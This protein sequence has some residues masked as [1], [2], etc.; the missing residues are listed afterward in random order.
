MPEYNVLAHEN[1]NVPRVRQRAKYYVT[2]AHMQLLCIPSICPV[3]PSK[4]RWTA[5]SYHLED[6]EGI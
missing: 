3:R 6:I 5:K 2:Y 1:L 4:G